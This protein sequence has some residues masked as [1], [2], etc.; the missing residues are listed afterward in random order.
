MAICMNFR[1]ETAL[2]FCKKVGDHHKGWTLCRIVREAI[3]RELIL[4]YVRQALGK[5]DSPLKRGRVL[6]AEFLN[7]IM[8]ATAPN[9]SFLR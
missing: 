5:D 9:Y 7:F 4:P 1:S 2:L 3:T 6:V 8:N